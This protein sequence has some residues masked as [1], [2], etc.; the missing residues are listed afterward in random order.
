MTNLTKDV[1]RVS[2]GL[3]REVGQNR[4]IVITLSPPDV[5]YFRAKG[6]RKRY[7]LTANRCYML[8]VEAQVRYD[9]KQKAKER[10][11]K[12]QSRNK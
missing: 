4:E 3:I 12:R 10:K 1:S 6:C 7:S 11:L 5:L 9:K 8:A 2:A